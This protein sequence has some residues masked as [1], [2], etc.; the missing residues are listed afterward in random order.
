MRRIKVVESRSFPDREF[1][2][3]DF[4][5]SHKQIIIRSLG[6][7]E[8]SPNLDLHFRGVDFLSIPTVFLG[9]SINT[10]TEAEVL[11]AQQLLAP[12]GCTPE[13]VWVLE[14]R[15]RRYFVVAAALDIAETDYPMMS[16]A[17]IHPVP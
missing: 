5:V 2:V 6:P 10:A 9:L 14:S 8:N 4:T 7:E 1:K 13:S 17:L 3:W 11:Q 16:T 12:R 15:G